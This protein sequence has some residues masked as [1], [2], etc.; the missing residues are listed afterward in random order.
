MYLSQNI[1]KKIPLINSYMKIR[2]IVESAQTRAGGSPAGDGMMAA[3]MQHLK[4]GTKKQRRAKSAVEALVNSL[5]TGTAR[6]G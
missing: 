4:R 5:P 3:Q 2:E 6:S 1:K